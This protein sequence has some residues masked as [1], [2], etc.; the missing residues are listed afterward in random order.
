MKAELRS[1]QRDARLEADKKN[2]RIAD[3]L[4]K[5]VNVVGLMDAMINSPTAPTREE[6]STLN[7]LR[8]QGGLNSL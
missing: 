5:M 6:L 2:G 1:A 7:T 4:C 3:R 8:I